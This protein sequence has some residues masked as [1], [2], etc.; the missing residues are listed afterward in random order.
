M[1]NNQDKKLRRAGLLVSVFAAATLAGCE[2]AAAPATE[3]AA[4]VVAE[5]K[6]A[7]P[8]FANYSAEQFYATKSYQGSAIN[9]N[10]QS[11]LVASDETGVFNLYRVSLDGK[12]WQPLT[13]STTDAMLP[14]DWFP[15]D[16]RVLYTA[17]QGGNEL[18]HL[19]VLETDGKV[20][21]LLR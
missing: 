5:Q 16:D 15:K 14:V 9:H 2:R 12:T 8:V 17:D 6:A 7:A 4:P 1:K 19:Y 21:G 20:V 11:L 3:P 18:H 10:G 13:N